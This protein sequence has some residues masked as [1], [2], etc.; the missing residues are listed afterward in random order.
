MAKIKQLNHANEVIYPVTHEDAVFD[1]DGN[2][3]S[4][5]LNF[6][7]NHSQSTHFSGDYNDLENKPFYDNRVF[8]IGK[9][10]FDGVT[11]GR[12]TM[13]QRVGSY[14]VNTFVKVADITADEFVAYREALM[15]GY[16]CT[17]YRYDEP[18]VMESDYV[19]DITND[20]FTTS[21]VICSTVTI[22]TETISIP[23]PGVYMIND[24][25]V[26]TIEFTKSTGELKV[27]DTKYL[28]NTS[29]I[30]IPKGE[31]YE[32]TD[33]S[34]TESEQTCVSEG[35]SEIFN[36]YANNIATG[37]YSHAEGDC[38]VA[39]GKYSH[40]EGQGTKAV[41]EASHTEGQETKASGTCSHAEGSNVTASGTC[42]HAEG[43]YTVAG[44]KYSH[45]EGRS[46]TSNGESSHSEGLDTS[47]SGACSHAEG[48]RT[49]AKGY[50]SHSEGYYTVAA[51]EYQHVQGKNNI[52]DNE[53]KYVHIV[54]NGDYS[55][56][57]NA[58]TLDWDG[59]AWFAGKIS[60]EATPTE[61]KDLTT[62]AYVDEKLSS[63]NAITL[64]GYSL[65]VGT[66][67]ELDAIEVKDPNTL[68]FEINDNQYY[69]NEVVPINISDGKLNLINHKYQKCLNMVDGTELVFPEVNGFTEIHLYFSASSDLSLSFPECK[70]RV[71][72]NIEAGRSYEIIATYNTME[73]L[74]NVIVYS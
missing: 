22:E 64:N 53:N 66:S 28:K 31:V 15:Q 23:S 41:G 17:F 62:K 4:E 68:Y 73:W 67:E 13:T 11:E 63:I 71:E 54:G 6:S 5:K 59:N 44:G 38:T 48:Q 58:H 20:I 50:A 69:E 49:E 35:E 47:A 34:E 61:A 30:N 8:E 2:S 14:R 57:S 56:K 27:I 72:P 39:R 26:F 65:W 1:S 3:I 24:Q 36:N 70:W 18:Y 7:Y 55:T 25:G 45:A 29:G 21:L 16:T 40:A 32:Y 12:V 19:E 42:S 9:F 43:E 37:Q 60:Q 74:V 10:E 51:G 33:Y 52:I 46:T